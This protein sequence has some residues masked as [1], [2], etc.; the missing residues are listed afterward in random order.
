[1]KNIF[2]ILVF[3]L[4][5]FGPLN[6]K[7]LCDLDVLIDPDTGSVTGRIIIEKDSKKNI[8]LNTGNVTVQDSKN[9]TVENGRL[10]VSKRSKKIT[11]NFSGKFPGSDGEGDEISKRGVS[12]TG[13]WY[14]VPDDLCVYSLKVTLP[15]IY[16]AV[17]EANSINV[18]A[19]KGKKYFNFLIE[20]P[21]EKVTLAASSDFVVQT[22]R[23]GD[24]EI[25]A[26]FSSAN[27]DLISIYLKNASDFI[28]LYEEMLGKYPYR[29]F[30]IVENFLP[31]GYSMPTY[32]LIGSRV[33]RLPF[34][35]ETSLGHEILHQWFGNSL[36]ID[37][38]YGNWSEGLTTYLADHF[39]D[40][41]E[42]RG[43]LYRKNQ[44]LDYKT[45]VAPD[46]DYPPSKF[47]FRKNDSDRSIG[48]GKVSL[49][50]HMLKNLS[51]EKEFLDALRLL[52]KE[53]SFQRVSYG[54]IQDVFE[55]TTRKKLNQFF[56]GWI[57]NPG[58]PLLS[59]EDFQVD[60]DTRGYRVT[61]LL[62]QHSKN[63]YTF[64]VFVTFYGGK[65]K[66]KYRLILSDRSRKFVVYL[67]DA[68]EKVHLDE[69][70]D[71]ARILGEDETAFRISDFLK[72]KKLNIIVSEKNQ[73]KYAFVLA[74][75]PEAEVIHPD[76]V[77]AEQLKDNCLVLDYS[78]PYFYR[79]FDLKQYSAEGTALRIRKNPL[80]DDTLYAY[81]GGENDQ[82]TKAAM[83]RVP[84]YGKYSDLV[85]DSGG[86]VSEKTLPVSADG[87]SY[88]LLPGSK[89]EKAIPWA[90]AAEE[91]PLNIISHK[92]IF[93]GEQHNIFN[94]HE[95]Q[96]E[97]IKNY[98]EKNK[99]NTVIG[100]E[101]FERTV[102]DSIDQYLKGKLSEREFLEKSKY[103]K[104]WGFDYRYYRDIIQFAKKNKIPVIALNQNSDLVRKIARNGI[105]SLT[106]EEKKLMPSSMDMSQNEYKEMLRRVFES[107]DFKGAMKFDN[108]YAAQVL[109]DET[110]AETVYDYM[111]NN[112]ASGIVVLAG[113]GHLKGGRGIP[114]RFKSRSGISG[115]VVLQDEIIR[116]GE[117][118]AY[119]FSGNEKELPSIFSG[120][121]FQA[122]DDAVSVSSLEENSNAYTSGFKAGDK[123][124]EM[125]KN[126]VNSVFELRLE[127]YFCEIN[128]QC[129]IKVIRKEKEFVIKLKLK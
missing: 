22:M 32:T 45:F 10:S 13:I 88:S 2:S 85:I 68:P 43:I 92:V 73:L 9:Y 3:F 58:L 27:K 60:T 125:N 30:A 107:H 80:S 70:Y 24:V 26:Y 28:K 81:L 44:M 89:K 59:L 63:V 121:K 66:R 6:A 86:T 17:S 126:R 31:T 52:V 34:I 48:Y 113:N 117:A 14:P 93:V 53:K 47:S 119:I 18:T 21:V 97:L 8:S 75:F 42:G 19:G 98:Y 104:T 25:A 61:F 128:Q 46:Q 100:L 40:D 56:A 122:D 96:L 71:T 69:T 77:R 41:M 62:K 110:M 101:M 64:P 120:I 105:E 83:R 35:P 4:V 36:F 114:N 50:F 102:Q 123:I 103:Y 72:L 91:L 90:G 39:Y 106:P 82:K 76:K 79:L 51:G 115:A 57:E 55:R 99:K 67:K 111:K 112:P 15:D 12:L 109:W 74:A 94:H 16:T 118:D 23:E 29:R 87:I 108:F 129:E 49:F 37:T 95:N 65:L 5:S 116:P 54:D 7:N 33:L 11:V 127:K 84:H 1:M 20:T 38:E 78:N 124:V